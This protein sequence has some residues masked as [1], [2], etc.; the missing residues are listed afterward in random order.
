MNK[1]AQTRVLDFLEK[2]WVQFL[3]DFDPRTSAGTMELVW[4]LVDK[5]DSG[6]IDLVTVLDVELP[7]LNKM[8]SER[9]LKDLDR[10]LRGLFDSIQMMS[11]TV[12]EGESL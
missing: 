10:R 3:Y 5:V 11:T 6:D 2:F 1:I 7:V 8:L 9:L 12:P 4:D